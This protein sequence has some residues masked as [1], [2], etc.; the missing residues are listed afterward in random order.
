ML[1]RLTILFVACSLRWTGHGIGICVREVR[2][3]ARCHD[4]FMF[5]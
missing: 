3:F 2:D 4:P 1:N 5:C